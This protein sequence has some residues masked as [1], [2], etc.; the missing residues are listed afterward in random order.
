[1]KNGSSKPTW[2]ILGA[3]AIGCLWASYWRQA[4]FKV[5]LI[6]QTP[7]PQNSIELQCEQ[8]HIQT[9]IEQLTVEQLL[10]ST[11]HIAYLF[12]STK[13]QH[14]LAAVQGILPRLDKQATVLVIQNG[15]AAERLSSVL[16]T[17][18]L[19]KGITTDGAYRTG[20]MSVVHA[21]KGDTHIGAE[22]SLLRVLPGDYLSIHFCSDITQRQ[23]Q[24][25]VMNCAV[26]GLTA[27]YQCRNGELLQNPEAMLRVSRLCKEACA[28]AGTLG[29]PEDFES[30]MA[31]IRAGLKVT[32]ANYSSLYDDIRNGRSTEIDYLNGYLCQMATAAGIACEENRRVVDAI[33][34]L[35]ST[36]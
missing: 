5:V 11:R 9:N 18:Q 22:K 20:P 35:E 23:W 19:Y 32:A 14:T 26:N 10:A 31:Q 8:Q 36:L 2:Y 34:Q 27:I 3:G 29:M 1:M 6:T 16:T 21:G 28:I 4:G 12:V 24:K 17:Q 33:K 15:M 7:R 13:A 30:I 25:L